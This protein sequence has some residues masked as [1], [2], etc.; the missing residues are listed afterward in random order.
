MNKANSLQRVKTK[1]GDKRQVP[2]TSVALKA[3][4]R[5]MKQVKKQERQMEGFSFNDDRLFPWW[6]GQQTSLLPTTAL[7]SRQFA[8]VF[9][10]AGCDDL[11]FQDLRHE[12]TSR[13]FERTKLSDIQV[14]R[15]TGHKDPRVLQRYANLPR[16]RPRRPT[17]VAWV[18]R[19][20]GLQKVLPHTLRVLNRVRNSRSRNFQQN[21]PV[22]VLSGAGYDF[23]ESGRPRQ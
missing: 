4:T 22:G 16:Q 19:A 23:R 10:A 13:L 14:S 11:R 7:L 21:R 9:A 5:Y 6:D 8:R 18:I 1:N 15:I 12:A 17:L 2:L 3:L 20:F